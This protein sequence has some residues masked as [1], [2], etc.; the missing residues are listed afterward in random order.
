[1]QNGTATLENNLV[2]SYKV[3]QTFTMKSQNPH[4]YI[5]PKGMK[6]YLQGKTYSQL[7]IIAKNST[8]LHW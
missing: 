1:M 7:F 8:T 5:Y 6:V 3:K 2:A 4:L